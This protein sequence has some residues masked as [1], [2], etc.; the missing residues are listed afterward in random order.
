[1]TEA[2]VSMA[3]V[4]GEPFLK[5]EPY[6]FEKSN[7][8]NRLA[9]HASTFTRERLMPPPTEVYTLHRKLFGT[10]NACVKI[11]AKIPCRHE[12]ESVVLAAAASSSSK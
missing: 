6:D 11:G 3:L 7:Y 4:M 8:Q 2:H 10:I 12:L 1:M 5:N 9:E